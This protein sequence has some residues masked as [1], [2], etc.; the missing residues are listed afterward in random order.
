MLTKI[1]QLFPRGKHAETLTLPKH[2][3]EL[4]GL[5]AIAVLSVMCTHTASRFG[6]L[7]LD[8]V[9]QFGW[10]GVDLFFVL[11]GFLITGI[12]LS[13]RHS[14]QYFQNFYARRILRIWPLYF[15]LVFTAFAI[16]PVI[17]SRD[18]YLAHHLPQEPRGAWV[19]FAFLQNL[20]R[21]GQPTHLLLGT[22][23]SLA[24]EEQFYFAWPLL[25]RF[26]SRRALTGIIVTIFAASPLV[27]WVAMGHHLPPG[28][29]YE[30]TACR[31][32]GLAIGALLAIALYSGSCSRG[33]LRNCSLAALAIGATGS[34]LLVPTL[35]NEYAPPFGGIVGFTLSTAGR[36][37]MLNRVLNCSPLQYVGRISY[38]LYLVHLPVFHILNSRVFASKAFF[39]DT[40]SGDLHV[41]LFGFTGC[42]L[43]AT[44]SWY[45][46]ESPIL[47]L[48]RFFVER[49][50]VTRVTTAQAILNR[51]ELSEEVGQGKQQW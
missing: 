19:Y 30:N 11:S 14:S 22:T 51:P 3:H 46:L 34:L 28:W 40:P 8:K 44:L 35:V 29:I 12:L 50:S 31:L 49:E 13:S 21:C 39:G 25:V 27:R 47:K 10:A 43:I 6:F 17:V 4:D 15:L 16:F 7:H 18:P 45:L 23:W 48:K 37:T 5:R 2:I 41:V 32:D 36:K 24:I 26:S 42:F 1:R 20:I 33:M 9:F 38:C